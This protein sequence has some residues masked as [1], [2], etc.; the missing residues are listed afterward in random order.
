MLVPLVG[1]YV[2]LSRS[3][4][5]RQPPLHGRAPP[6]DPR[7]GGSLEARSAPVLW[8]ASLKI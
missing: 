2:N 6:L 5:G 8:L 3:V 4:P 7:P 1:K